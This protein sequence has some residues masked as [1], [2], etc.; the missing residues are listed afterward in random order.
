V[1]ELIQEEGDSVALFLLPGIQYYT[2]QL[3]NMPILTQAAHAKGIIVG[4]D[5]AHAA[6]NVPLYLHDWGIDFAAWCSYK[7][8]NAGPGGIGAIFVH[9]TWTDSP[10]LAVSGLKGWWGNSPTS[11]F[12]MREGLFDSFTRKHS[13][14]SCRFSILLID[15]L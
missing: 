9:E 4:A 3:F 14:S 7:F 1:R 2:G 13:S 11:R 12:S 15:R 5:L 8:L 10:K 6:G